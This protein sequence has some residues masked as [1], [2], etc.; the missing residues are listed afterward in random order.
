MKDDTEHPDRDDPDAERPV[1]HAAFFTTRWTIVAAAGQTSG[2]D[3]HAAMEELCQTYWYPLYAHVR[4]RGHSKEDAEDLT[5]A[6][7]ERLLE[8]NPLDGLAPERGRFRSF[9]LASLKNFL[10]N[11]WDKSRAQ[12]RGG[13]TVPLSLDWQDAESRYRI[14][15]ADHLSPDKLYDRAWALTLLE[16]VMHRLEYANAENPNFQRLKPCLTVGKQAIDYATVSQE[17]GISENAA[18]VAAHRLRRQYRELLRAEIA[19][20]LVGPEHIEDEL[21]ALYGAFTE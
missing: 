3:A 16:R 7:F 21:H 14:E 17:L 5:Q 6:F 19:E 8:K 18:R 11:E 12:K 15:P 9:L 20:T 4:R 10:A 2:A 13:G 1:R